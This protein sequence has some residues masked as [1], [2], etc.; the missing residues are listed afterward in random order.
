MFAGVKVLVPVKN[1]DGIAEVVSHLRRPAS[2]VSVLKD[3][4]SRRLL[5]RQALVESLVE[6]E[7]HSHH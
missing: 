1:C 2:Y 3:Q 4:E 5:S 6:R 7:Q